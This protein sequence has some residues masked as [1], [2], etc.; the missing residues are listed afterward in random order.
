MPSLIIPDT[1]TIYIYTTGTYASYQTLQ[2]CIT[3]SD[4]VDAPDG[5]DLI[6][7]GDYLKKYIFDNKHDDIIT[8]DKVICTDTRYWT[9]GMYID[10]ENNDYKLGFIA[11]TNI[12]NSVIAWNLWETLKTS[13]YRQTQSN[14]NSLLNNNTLQYANSSDGLSSRWNVKNFDSFIYIEF[15]YQVQGL[16]NPSNYRAILRLVYDIENKEIVYYTSDLGTVLLS[17]LE[18]REY[19]K[20][21][22]ID[23]CTGTIAYPSFRKSSI[24]EVSYAPIT[25]ID[26]MEATRFYMLTQF[27]EASAWETL[28]VG[29]KYLL[30]LPYDTSTS[31]GYWGSGGHEMHCAIAIDVTGDIE[32]Q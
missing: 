9:G 27:P 19:A 20:T 12:Y 15:A 17:T 28:H 23:G 11:S 31:T 21:L 26:G 18:S 5:E 1:R 14:A 25:R 10:G 30:V 32:N 24:E 7:R 4:V 8:F 22:T 2:G 3:D 16:W 13:P 29:D 6:S